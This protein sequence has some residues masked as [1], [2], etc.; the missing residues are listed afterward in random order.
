MHATS[1][2]RLQLHLRLPFVDVGELLTA[3]VCEETFH[4]HTYQTA[5]RIGVFFRTQSFRALG[6]HH[7]VAAGL[8]NVHRTDHAFYGLVI[9][10]VERIAGGAGDHGVEATLDR[11]LGV[12]PD[13]RN[14]FEVA[15]NDLA[16]VYERQAAMLVDHGVHCQHVAELA[17]DLE[18]LFVQRIA[19]EHAVVRLRM[20]HE[21][22]T[23]K[24]GYRVLVRHSR[25]DHFAPAREAG[26]EVRLHQPGGDSHVS[27]DE[28]AVQFYRRAARRRSEIYMVGVVA[29]EV[30]RHIYGVQHPGVADQFFQLRALVRTMQAGSHQYG[31]VCWLHAGIEQLPDNFR[32]QQAVRYRPGDVADEYAGS[33]LSPCFL[34]QRAGIDRLGQCRAHGPPRVG[35]HRHF[36]LADHGDVPMVR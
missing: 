2:H 32:Q 6:D 33:L 20:R 22:G 31:D 35:L 11:Y 28:T 34:G 15:R 14:C 12:A 16:V 23:V 25:R 29:G 10:R 17:Y 30:V 18:L 13:K 5:L 24:C 1:F 7:Q 8:E 9:S 19:L 26:H 27:L 4:A 36:R 21:A 3:D